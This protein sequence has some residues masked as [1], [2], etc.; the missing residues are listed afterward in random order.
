MDDVTLAALA[1]ALT[2][3][4]VLI[5]MLW[6]GRL[7]SLVPNWQ[8]AE[9]TKSQVVNEAPK[10]HERMLQTGLGRILDFRCTGLRSETV[11]V[12]VPKCKMQPACSNLEWKYEHV[13]TPVDCRKY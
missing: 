11:S 9:N 8:E 1:A 7:A 2:T 10:Q 4:A 5:S 13:Q 3:A 6:L 12:K